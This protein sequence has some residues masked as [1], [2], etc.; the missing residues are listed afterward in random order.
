MAE[1]RKRAKKHHKHNRGSKYFDSSEDEDDP[2]IPVKSDDDKDS[3]HHEFSRAGSST[4]TLRDTEKKGTFDIK[5]LTDEELKTKYK[6]RRHKCK[7]AD[8]KT[9]RQ[10]NGQVCK[11]SF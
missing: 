3:G 5:P 2:G 8:I 7:L 1:K 10:I 11:I 4:S 6:Y 9:V